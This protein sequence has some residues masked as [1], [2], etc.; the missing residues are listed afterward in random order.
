MYFRISNEDHME[1]WTY[2]GDK[3]FQIQSR[4]KYLEESK[5]FEEH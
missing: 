2:L 5:V 1:I 4:T 3:S